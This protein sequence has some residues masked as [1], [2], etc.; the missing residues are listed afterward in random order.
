M[1]RAERGMSVRCAVGGVWVEVGE[2]GGN[3]LIVTRIRRPGHLRPDEPG[4]DLVRNWTPPNAALIACWW[5]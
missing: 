2:A 3:G 5:V 1:T 4:V